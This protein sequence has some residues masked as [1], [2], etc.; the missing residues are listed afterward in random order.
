[1]AEAH[2]DATAGAIGAPLVVW[3]IAFFR[4]GSVGGVRSMSPGIVVLERSQHVVVFGRVSRIMVCLDLDGSKCQRRAP[5]RECVTSA[6][7]DFC[8]VRTA[9]WTRQA[10]L[11]SVPFV[12]ALMAKDHVPL[13]LHCR[14]ALDWTRWNRCLV[15][16]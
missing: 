14:R 1:M 11:V 5:G 16:R 10:V 15:D 8:K 4:I 7:Y 3:D 12:L 6:S 13:A 2:R 9:V